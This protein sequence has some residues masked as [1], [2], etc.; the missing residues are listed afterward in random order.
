MKILRVATILLLFAPLAACSAFKP[1]VQYED[2]KV[3]SKPADAD[4]KFSTGEF[5][6]TPCVVARPLGEP[7]TLSV[8]KRGYKTRWVKVSPEPERSDSQQ[9]AAP[10]KDNNAF[11]PNPIFV[12]LE[13]EWSK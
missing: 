8:R 13:P 11:K 2:I 5:C 4:V 12:T 6:M 9:P 1:K 10:N 3:R 7:F